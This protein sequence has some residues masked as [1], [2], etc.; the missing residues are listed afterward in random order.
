MV[1]RAGQKGALALQR[2]VA[3]AALM[4]DV[5]LSRLV[6]PLHY[7]KPDSTFEWMA[8]RV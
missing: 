1:C 4:F 6:L 5:T 7:L 2:A 8:E 3:S